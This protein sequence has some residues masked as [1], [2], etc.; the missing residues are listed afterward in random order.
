MRKFP[1]LLALAVFSATTA[2]ALA[3]CTGASETVA[4]KE[5]DDK[6][7]K[8]APSNTATA[9]STATPFLAST[10]TPTATTAPTSTPM[11]TP[12]SFPTATVTATP[13]A[14]PTDSPTPTSTPSVVPTDTATITPTPTPTL[15]PT[16]TTTPTPTI[17]PTPTL[18]PAETAKI[19]NVPVRVPNHMV[20]ATWGWYPPADELT[21][22]VD[23]QNDIEF[24]GNHG[25]Y[26]MV[27]GGITI[28]NHDAYFGLQ[29]NVNTG[30]RGGW[31]TSAKAQYSR[32]GM[33]RATNTLEDH[34]IH[35][36]RRETTK[37]ALH[38]LG[39]PSTGK[40]GNT[41]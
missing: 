26:L 11:P 29:T 9:V 2:L 35:G 32:F 37:A 28:G 7:I 17:T 30:P 10:P 5:V 23:I 1:I 8:V 22:V 31:R 33:Y 38:P 40:K 19:L 24:R 36:S 39:V 18:T 20:A 21:V 16:P 15:T 4:P 41:P 12:T 14:T 34:E 6:V 13:T 3:A 27:C 25:L